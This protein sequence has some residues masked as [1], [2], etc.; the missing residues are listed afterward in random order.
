MKYNG[1]SNFSYLFE[2]EFIWLLCSSFNFMRYE[3]ENDFCVLFI[4]E[5][6]FYFEEMGD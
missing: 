4:E 5:Q 2:G 6:Y 1:F 3:D